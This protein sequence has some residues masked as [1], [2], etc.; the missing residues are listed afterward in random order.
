M[1]EC[2]IKCAVLSVDKWDIA[3]RW[4]VFEVGEFVPVGVE[5]LC[6]V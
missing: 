4:I 6:E 3:E 5:V 2:Y 1:A